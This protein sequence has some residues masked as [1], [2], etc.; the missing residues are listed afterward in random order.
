MSKISL[1]SK[2]NIRV[3]LF[4][5]A[6]IAITVALNVSASLFSTKFNLPLYMDSIATI[7]LASLCGFFPAVLGAF[8]TNLV[9]TLLGKLKLIF[10]IC[11]ILT[12]CGA[13][14]VFYFRCKNE[15]E[16]FSLDSFMFAGILSAFSNGILGSV[17]AA[18]MGYNLSPIE[19][20]LYFLTDNIFAANLAGGFILNLIDKFFA[21]FISYLIYLFARHCE[22][23]KAISF[24][25]S[26]PYGRSGFCGI[27]LAS[28]IF[29]FSHASHVR[30]AK[31]AAIPTAAVASA[32]SPTS[33]FSAT[34]SRISRFWLDDSK[35]GKTRRH[36]FFLKP[37]YV[38]AIV[39]SFTLITGIFLKNKIAT[40]FSKEY[41]ELVNSE[42][43]QNVM[44]GGHKN[45]PK[46]ARF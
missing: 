31:A 46:L 5:F 44:G 17:F 34:A 8:L 28:P 20:G 39:A 9:I 18:V 12:A 43:S 29:P 11:Q 2:Q 14:F 42:L 19:K 40:T 10:C 3:L 15:N 32:D 37:E 25:R 41:N 23:S 7:A 38:F 4:D 26:L 1:N 13:C 24:G 6:C 16:E 21:A 45:F 36:A 33:V 35:N 27:K 30:T 22:R